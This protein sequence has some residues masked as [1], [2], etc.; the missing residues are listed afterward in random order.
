MKL[1]DAV[2]KTLSS[3]DVHM[4]PQEIRDQIKKKYSE[5]YGTPAHIRNVEKGHYKN[6]DNA[7]LAQIYTLVGTSI[8]FSCDKTIKPMKVSLTKKPNLGRQRQRL[9][10]KSVIRVPHA[11]VEIQ[12]ENKVKD[13]LSN[14]EKYHQAY[15]KA[16]TFRGP[17]LYF[18]Q[19]ALKT[20]K[21]PCLLAHLEY[22]YATLASWGM[23][24]MGK[25]GSK[26]Q[27]F[28]TF[29]Q[30]IEPL[31][32]ML[33]EAQR[34]NLQR[35]REQNWTLLKKIFQNINVMASRTSL[36]GNSKVMHHIL[37]NVV[38]PIDREYTLRYLHG[39]TTIKN[40]LDYEWELMK[41]II[42]NFFIPIVSDKKFR[43]KARN[44]MARKKE[45]PWNTSVLKIV[46]NLIIGS[47]K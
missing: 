17:S 26:M 42:L 15:Y 40:D 6:I 19:R 7:L 37:P 12:Y 14:A 39:N 43:L 30:S 5:L 21:K 46:D 13:I 9:T 10:N 22:V 1:S 38:P 41:Q 23:H 24:R 25:G 31:E 47:K 3:T 27:S 11:R 28:E 8:T 45:Y 35:M 20:R 33:N 16:N 36:V 29:C 32:N 2:I 4:T 44:W 18:H 34:F